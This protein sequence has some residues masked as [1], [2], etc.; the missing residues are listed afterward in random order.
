M[1]DYVSE[2][3]QIEAIRRWWARNGKAVILGLLL[4]VAAVM[5][6]RWWQQHQAERALQ[7]SEAYLQALEAL[8]GGDPARALELGRR[9]EEGFPRSG[10]VH[11]A[12]LL[13]ARAALAQGDAGAARAHLERLLE[14][15]AP[16]PLKG[17]ARL[18]QAR[19]LLQEGRGHEALAALDRLED[20]AYRGL[21]EELRGDIL[22]H[23][24]RVQEARA[25]YGAALQAASDP[26]RQLRLVTK[27]QAVGLQAVG[28]QAAGAAEASAGA[29]AGKP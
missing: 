16:E 27:L 13:E 26:A 29:P 2:R 6:G 9:V 12:R 17:L 28:L 25:A 10:Y 3:E 18:R 5:G 8:E 20:P 19:L 21:K 11:L 22:L 24:G 23:A 14:S 7:A 1:V 4:G 15:R